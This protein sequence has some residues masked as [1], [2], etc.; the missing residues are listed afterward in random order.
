MHCY[1]ICQSKDN[2]VGESNT[3][4]DSVGKHYS[5][6]NKGSYEIIDDDLVGQHTI[7]IYY[8]PLKINN[9]ILMSLQ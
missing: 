8:N 3:Y 5:H 4:F 2:L 7:R 6:G 1:I 9:L